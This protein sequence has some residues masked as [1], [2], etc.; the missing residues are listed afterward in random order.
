MAKE[1][2]ITLKPGTLRWYIAG[3]LC[4]TDQTLMELQDSLKSPLGSIPSESVLTST[5]SRLKQEGL[6][7][8]ERKEVCIQKK[9]LSY[10]VYTLTPRGKRAFEFS[11]A[12]LQ[13]QN[14]YITSITIGAAPAA[15]I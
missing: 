14:E 4:R 5:T 13:D 1:L 9:K 15:R 11:K 6:I 12:V 2:R 3:E 8:T 7:G 10:R